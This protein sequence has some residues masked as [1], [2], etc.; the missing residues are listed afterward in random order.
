MGEIKIRQRQAQKKE[1]C[2]IA[3][4]RGLKAAFRAKE[5]DFGVDSQSALAG[6]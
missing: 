1:D 4:G 2:S 3:K 5:T 6:N